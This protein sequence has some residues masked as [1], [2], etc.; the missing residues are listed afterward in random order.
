VI[1]VGHSFGAVSLLLA[2]ARD[3]SP[4]RGLALLDPTIFVP[5]RMNRIAAER[6]AGGAAQFDLTRA[7]LRRRNRFASPAAAAEYFSHR[8]LFRGWSREA[9]EHYARAVLEPDP[10]GRGY[11]LL[12]SPE[13]EAW[14]YQSFYPDT[15]RDVARLDPLLPVL[16]VR[17]ESSDT[18]TA[19]AARDLQQRLPGVVQA[20]VPK[21]GHL[22]PLSHPGETAELVEGWLARAQLAAFP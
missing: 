17:G 8:S 21:A 3:P 12:W 22:F 11:H 15:W 20:V 13:W 4:F 16:A 18:F 14:Y 6:A 19:A 5:E 10:D 7:A 2:A 9:V 1:G